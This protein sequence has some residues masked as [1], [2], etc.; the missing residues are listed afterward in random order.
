V[1]YPVE[2][3]HQRTMAR[4]CRFAHRPT[5]PQA[6]PSRKPWRVVEVRLPD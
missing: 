2:Q 4:L 3:I 5:S 1:R 6:G